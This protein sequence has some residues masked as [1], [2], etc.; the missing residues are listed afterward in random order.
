[1]Q[2]L[3]KFI[4]SNISLELNFFSQISDITTQTLKKSSFD[5]PG[6]APFN[7][8]TFFK[9]LL[10]LGEMSRHLIGDNF[11]IIQML[12]LSPVLHILFMFILILAIKLKNHKIESCA[13]NEKDIASYGND[14]YPTHFMFPRFIQ[15]YVSKN[16]ENE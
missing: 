7:D 13:K 12:S 14:D 1:L 5:L 9:T 6:S 2:P 11:L 15:I 3:T 10:K 8:L 4:L 16:Q